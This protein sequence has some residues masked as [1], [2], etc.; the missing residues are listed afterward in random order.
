MPR[1]LIRAKEHDRSRSL[2][3]LGLAW[4]EHF[5]VHGPGG[6]QGMPVEHGDEYAGFIADCYALDD[7]GKLLYDQAFLSRP[8]GCDK[9]GLEGRL[10]LFEAFGPCRFAGWA[11]GGEEYFWNGFRYV[12]EPGE[13]MG[14][15]V[16]SPFIRCMATE[17][18]Q[19]GNVYDTIYVNLTEGPLSEFPEIKRGAGLTRTLIPGGGEIT[20]S[21][22]SSASKDGGKETFV[23]FDETHLYNTPELRR[24]Y[25]T[26]TRNMRKRK[27]EGT[28]YI[29]GT[30]MFAPGQESV[31]ETTY[32]QAEMI[33]EG[34]VKRARLLFDHR[35]GEV[36]DLSDEEALREGIIDAYGDALAWN[37]LDGF[38]DEFYNIHASQANSR[39]YFLNSRTSA[40]DAWIDV[41]EW[42]NC[43]HPE[44]TLHDGDLITLGFDGAIRN[45][46]TALVACRVEDGHLQPLEIG[47]R[48]TVWERPAGL[49]GDN[50][51]VDREEVD[52]AVARAFEQYEVCG[53][54]ADPPHWQDY[55]DKWNSEY[56]DDLRVK[57]SAARP[58]EWWT[59][60][61]RVMEAALGR[62]H[63]AV[64]AGSLSHDGNA[65]LTRH[66]LNAYRKI[67]RNALL[68]SKEHP[69]SDKKIDAAMAATLAYE[70]RADAVALGIT[71][72]ASMGGYTF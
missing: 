70:C 52:A 64:A 69:H 65:T 48:I 57:A 23:A 55:V 49:A 11:Q 19:T 12:Y 7:N 5:V 67:T 71:S 29:E 36:V 17:E 14:K 61:T 13:P 31:A 24:M 63:D 9:S 60:R 10:G 28:W 45:D 16:R 68:I 37:D 1:N 59:T 44:T 53:F 18:E 62:F 20:P 34:R 72:D 54:Y 22:S 3:W 33:Q 56:A 41:D 39:R 25:E 46:S 40:D 27:R 15:R 30:T 32:K 58:I 42:A 50:W 4:I 2:G 43:S 8:K 47:G 6:V 21:T 35:W 51:Q 26:V 66:V 38:V